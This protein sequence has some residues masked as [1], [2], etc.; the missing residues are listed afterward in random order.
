MRRQNGVVRPASLPALESR[1]RIQPV[2]VHHGRRQ[3]GAAQ[4]QALDHSRRLRRLSQTTADQQ[5]AVRGQSVQYRVGGI[6]G[7]YA[8]PRFG[9]RQERRLD[10]GRRDRRY[11]T[12]G[13][14]DGNQAGAGA[15]GGYA[16]KRRRAK[17]VARSDDCHRPPERAFVRF[18][19]A[20]RQRGSRPGF[21][22]KADAN[23]VVQSVRNADVRH[24]H[25][26]EV[27][28]SRKVQVSALGVA[29]RNRNV[30]GYRR[31]IYI[32]AV[33][34]HA[35]G[36]VQRQYLGM[37]E[38]SARAAG[39]GTRKLGERVFD[40]SADGPQ[41]SCAEYGVYDEVSRTQQRAQARQSGIVGY[42]DDGDACVRR[43]GEFRV[44]RRPVSTQ[45]CG[46]PRSPA[47]QMPGGD[48]AV[49]AVVPWSD[50]DDD[51]NAGERPRHAPRDAGYG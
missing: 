37:A 23:V 35:G 18:Q 47:A 16:R 21:G 31:G 48:Q 6:V 30:R 4:K 42:G 34:V 44:R 24:L 20:R 11:E 40:D 14:G 36:K 9:Q 5:R 50:E 3:V 22:Q 2:G 38:S 7:D 26:P 10:G 13:N 1:Q 12:F 25:A 41:P 49:R 29:E 27:C 33:G 28:R 39:Y 46:G 8:P 43:G 17:K 51:R 19:R 32:G 15:R 45:V